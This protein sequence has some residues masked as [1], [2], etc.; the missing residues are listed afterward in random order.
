M[1]F[2]QM[3]KRTSSKRLG[4]KESTERGDDDYL[5]NN[6]T[7]EIGCSASSKCSIDG[8]NRRDRLVETSHASSFQSWNDVGNSMVQV[9][10]LQQQQTGMTSTSRPAKMAD[11]DML[12]RN[13]ERCVRFSECVVV[14]A[15]ML[16]CAVLAA[17][18]FLLSTTGE[19]NYFHAEVGCKPLSPFSYPLSKLRTHHPLPPLLALPFFSSLKAGQIQSLAWQRSRSA[20]RLEPSRFSPVQF[21]PPPKLPVKIGPM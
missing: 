10:R 5:D 18:V 2:I 17:A 6:S 19:E 9:P 21:H 14:G 1:R 15:L 11:T 16:T 3:T 20:V 12:A 13:E 8:S 7:S 4:F